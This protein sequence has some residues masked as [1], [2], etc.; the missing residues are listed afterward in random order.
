MFEI[1]TNIPYAPATD[2]LSSFLEQLQNPYHGLQALSIPSSY[3]HIQFPLP[4]PFSHSL[5]PQGFWMVISSAWNSLRTPGLVNFYSCFIKQC[6]P[7]LQLMTLHIKISNATPQK[8]QL[9]LHEFLR[10]AAYV[11]ASNINENN[12][13]SHYLSNGFLSL[14]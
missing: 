8:S 5:L 13:Y 6:K 9:S 12:H 7:F 4:S 2:E 10:N 14:H 3:S 1:L 11:P